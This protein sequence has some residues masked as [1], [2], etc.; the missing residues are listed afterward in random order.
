MR[1]EHL[2][3]K[4]Y[5]RNDCDYLLELVK[6]NLGKLSED[7]TK[8]LKDGYNQIEKDEKDAFWFDCL[9]FNNVRINVIRVMGKT[10]VSFGRTQ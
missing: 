2:D 9:D 1:H 10:H 5:F 8:Q 6:K 4:I 7:D 3:V